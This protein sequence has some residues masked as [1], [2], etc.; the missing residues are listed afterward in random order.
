[1][2]RVIFTLNFKKGGLSEMND[3]VFLFVSVERIGFK[4]I[5]CILRNLFFSVLHLCIVKFQHNIYSNQSFMMYDIFI[6]NVKKEILKS[7]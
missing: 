4:I 6:P 5:F 3:L 1:M 2:Q 7:P